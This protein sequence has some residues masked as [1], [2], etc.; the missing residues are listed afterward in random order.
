[1]R[2]FEAIREDLLPVYDGVKMVPKKPT[3]ST[4]RSACFDLFS[5]SEGVVM[6]NESVKIRTGIK[7]YM[8]ENEALMLYGRSGMGI[9]GLVLANTVGVIDADY[10]SNESND[11][12]IIVCLRNLSHTAQQINVGDKVAQVMFIATLP[13]VGGEVKNSTRKGGF[14]STGA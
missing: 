7:A 1:M 14:G 5:L 3:K 8:M 2:G 9:K 11:G 12:E 6:P 13:A 4:E 10:Y